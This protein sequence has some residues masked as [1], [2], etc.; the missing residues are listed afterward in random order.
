MAKHTTIVSMTYQI[1]GESEDYT[2]N[3]PVTGDT[4]ST[5]ED[6]MK[7]IQTAGDSRETKDMFGRLGKALISHMAQNTKD[8]K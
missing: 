8:P 5:V 3:I 1:L 7:Q 4:Q 6:I 2:I